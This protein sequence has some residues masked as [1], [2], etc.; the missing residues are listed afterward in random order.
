MRFRIEFSAEAER[1]FA[2]IFDHLFENYRAFGE[3]VEAALDHSEFTLNKA[4]TRLLR[5]DS[6]G[7]AGFPGSISRRQSRSPSPFTSLKSIEAFASSTFKSSGTGGRKASD[8]CSHP[9]TEPR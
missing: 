8:P 2:L 1:D 6:G 7:L 4:V 3:T 9:V 5:S